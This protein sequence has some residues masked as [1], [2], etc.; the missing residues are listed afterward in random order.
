[1]DLIWRSE[2]GIKFGADLIW[3]SEKK[4]KFG[5]FCHFALIAPNFLHA[6]IYPNKVYDLKYRKMPLYVRG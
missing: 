4:I 1:M 3:R 5:D 6:K 2:K